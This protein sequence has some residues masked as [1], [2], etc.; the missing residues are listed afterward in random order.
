M[1]EKAIPQASKIK[2]P[3]TLAAFVSLVDGQ[4]AESN[5]A[6]NVVASEGSHALWYSTVFNSTADNETLAGFLQKA[7][8]TWTVK[9]GIDEA[10]TANKWGAFVGLSRGM[11]GAAA[12]P[13]WSGAE[14]IIDPYSQ[15]KGGKVLMTLNFIWNFQ[16]VRPSN[17]ARIK[18]S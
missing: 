6:L 3:E 8:V 10:T 5:G 4:H 16:L 18:Y 7:G 14:L 17:F 11:A 1:T 13:V 2:G 12:A 9:G 15:A